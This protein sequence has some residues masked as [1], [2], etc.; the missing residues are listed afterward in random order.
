MYVKKIFLVLRK[1]LHLSQFRERALNYVL[2]KYVILN[3]RVFTFKTF[4][5]IILSKFTMIALLKFTTDV[6]LSL[7]LLK[8]G[9]KRRV[10]K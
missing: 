1:S 5:I 9:V 6:F 8:I 4:C 2:I 10:S 7:L 3:E